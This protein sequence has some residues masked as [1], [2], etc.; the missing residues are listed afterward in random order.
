MVGGTFKVGA[1]I[2]QG[3][4]RVG[5]E[6]DG[7]DFLLPTTAGNEGEVIVK[8]ADDT[9]SWG[10]APA[11]AVEIFSFDQTTNAAR[12]IPWGSRAESSSANALQTST[13]AVTHDTVLKKIALRFESD[14]GACTITVA[15]LASGAGAVTT[16]ETISFTPSTTVG[17]INIV[18]FTSASTFVAG[19]AFLLNFDPT[20]VPNDVTGSLTM[21]MDPTS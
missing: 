20:N 12:Y 6:A 17:E 14:P 5:V 15:K 4:V 2:E 16:M 18:T 3:T 11:F 13:F 21:Q 19:D 7:T 8:N 9:T 10:V 1:K